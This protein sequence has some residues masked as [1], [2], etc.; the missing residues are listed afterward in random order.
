MEYHARERLNSER[1]RQTRQTNTHELGVFSS[2]AQRRLNALPQMTAEMSTT[3]TA[4]TNIQNPHCIGRPRL[5]FT[6]PI[7]SLGVLFTLTLPAIMADKN[8]NCSA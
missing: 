8:C 2:D 1:P 6:L 4:E 5:G 7:T 3:T